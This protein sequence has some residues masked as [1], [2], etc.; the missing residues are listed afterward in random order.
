ML[1]KYPARKIIFPI[2]KTKNQ[3]AIQ[4]IQTQVSL[5]LIHP[6]LGVATATS[7][8]KVA[9]T[10]PA[11]SATL[12]IADGKTLTASDNA[13]V[14]GTNTGDQTITLTGDVTG[15]G[16][17]SFATTIGSGKV[18]S[19]MLAATAIVEVSDEIT[20]TAAQTS[21]TI[22]HAKGTNRTIKMFINGVRISNTAYS[23]SSTT[24]TYTKANN[25]GYELKAGDRVQFDYSY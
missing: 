14:S 19:T 8:N 9:I 18:T 3:V 11:S 21:F 7:I 12:T 13:T 16:T 6:T 20:A 10:A 25:G 17:G 4:R 2:L 22:T 23:D 24:I 5:L 1:Q 15:S